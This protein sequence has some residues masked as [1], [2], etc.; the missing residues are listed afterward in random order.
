MRV[1][2]WPVVGASQSVL[3]E[4]EECGKGEKHGNNDGGV[5]ED[6]FESASCVER[7]TEVVA[8]S[9]STAD[10]SASFLDQDRSDQN[11]GQ[12]YLDIGKE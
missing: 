9:E 5:E 11:Y 3:E 8:T 6:L 4:V 10:L 12:D 1:L 7:R 2:V